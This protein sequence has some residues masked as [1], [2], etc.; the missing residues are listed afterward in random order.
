[1]WWFI[2]YIWWLINMW[3]EACYGWSWAN[4]DIFLVDLIHLG[5][6]QLIEL[7][8]YAYVAC[9]AMIEWIKCVEIKFE[10]VW[11][12]KFIRWLLVSRLN[13]YIYLV[14]V[15]KQVNFKLDSYLLKNGSSIEICPKLKIRASWD[16]VWVWVIKSI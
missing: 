3:V 12:D 8:I 10:L 9:Y 16:Q 11:M 2:G 14:K 4:Q 1:L 15:F 6:Y 13:G 7:D 5:A